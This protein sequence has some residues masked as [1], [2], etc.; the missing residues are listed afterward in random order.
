[1][2]NPTKV[3]LLQEPKANYTEVDISFSYTYWKPN[4]KDQPVVN[5]QKKMGPFEIIK[6]FIFITHKLVDLQLNSTPVQNF[7]R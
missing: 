4:G 2:M 5:L 3:I 1:M 7:I 6:M